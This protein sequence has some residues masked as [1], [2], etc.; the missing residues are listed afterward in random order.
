[1]V[2]KLSDLYRTTWDDKMPAKEVAET[3]AKNKDKLEKN[4]SLFPKECVYM[5]WN[6]DAPD[7]PGNPE[8]TA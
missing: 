1:M 3:W 2:F 8:A 7:I 6:Y 5:R 4:I